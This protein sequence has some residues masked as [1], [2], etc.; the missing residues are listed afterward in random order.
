M[1]DHQRETYQRNTALPGFGEAGQEKLLAA[2]VL[3]VGA[4]GLGSA[5]LH[6][7]TA[8]GV[9]YIGIA[10]GDVLDPSNLNRQ[11]LYRAA[12]VGRPKAVLAARRLLEL[13]PA[14]QTAVFEERF[15]AGR[16]TVV[17]PR[18][19]FV[20]DGTDNFLSKFMINDVCVREKIPFCHCGAAEYG[21]QL[22][23]VVFGA[24]PAPCLRCVFPEAPRPVNRPPG[25]LGALPGI[26]GA[27]QA[28]EAVKYLTGCGR[29]M[30]G[31]LLTLDL[32]S[33]RFREIP[34]KG[35]KNCSVCAPMP[36]PFHSGAVLE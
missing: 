25:V 4:G 27:L 33:G 22:M 36:R 16:L 17:A 30:T 18:Y 21:G 15:D 23:T 3:V 5:A 24:V 32:L 12:D 20:I 19:D 31:R 8:A 28:A 10:D 2:R 29:L 13:N 35:N 1:T 11:V 26:F 6:Y 14:L 34:V 9:G 7:L